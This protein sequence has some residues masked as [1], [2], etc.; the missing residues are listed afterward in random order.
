MQHYFNIVKV[1]YDTLHIHEHV[2]NAVENKMFDFN[3]S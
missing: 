3:Q 1:F 2:K